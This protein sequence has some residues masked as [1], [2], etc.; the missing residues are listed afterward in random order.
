VT[1]R[2]K[3]K[4]RVANER[5]RQDWKV[6]DK[7]IRRSQGTKGLPNGAPQLKNGEKGAKAGPGVRD[8]KKKKKEAGFEKEESRGIKKEKKNRKPPK[9]TPKTEKRVPK[10]GERW[11]QRKRE[12]QKKEAS[13][14][15]KKV[16][17]ETGKKRKE[18]FRGFGERRVRSSTTHLIK[19][20]ERRERERKTRGAH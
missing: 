20:I 12:G 9:E 8:K 10:P 19:K 2:K 14:R 4:E 3:K 1:G 5:G 13:Q 6:R 15:G 17:S 7:E 16:T 11:D 18:K